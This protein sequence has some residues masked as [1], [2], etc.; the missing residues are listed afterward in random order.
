M[1]WCSDK[2]GIRLTPMKIGAY[3]ALLIVLAILYAPMSYSMMVCLF[4]LLGLFTASQVISYALVA[5]SS[6]V[7]MTATAVSVV[8]ILTQSGYVLYQNIFSYLLL[9]QGDMRMLAG[10]PTYSLDDY[11]FAA[12]M[13]PLG[14]LLAIALLFGLR[15]TYCRRA[16]G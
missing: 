15:E 1:G 13:L 11:Q 4:F 7:S 12:M 9:K 3:S 10:V 16:Q 6:D 2:W 5:E 14:L 8:S